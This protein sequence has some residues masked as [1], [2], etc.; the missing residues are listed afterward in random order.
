MTTLVD[1]GEQLLRLERSQQTRPPIS[2]EVRDLTVEDAYAIQSA[3]VSA[4]ERAGARVV[5]AKIG[6]TS[7]AIQRYFGVFEPDFGLLFDEMSISSGDVVDLSTLI[8]PR[9]E[10]EIAIITDRDLRGPGLSEGDVEA[11][12]AAVAP[13]LE[14]VDSRIEDWR[15]TVA[16]TIAD[17]GS[18]SLFVLGDRRPLTEVPPLDEVVVRFGAEGEPP[19]VATG[20]AVMGHPFRSV[21]WLANRLGSLGRMIPAGS[22][23][24]SGSFTTALECRPG[25]TFSADFAGLGR[26]SLSFR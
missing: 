3:Y 17:N 10:P 11:A 26:V 22:V 5:G 13:S 18:S 9:I 24:L 12:I 19:I 1:I 23:L 20:A 25:T 14:I 21:A 16:D 6:C 7:E 8:Q 4:R 15:I 2:D